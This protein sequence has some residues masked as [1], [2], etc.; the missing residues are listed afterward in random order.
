MGTLINALAKAIVDQAQNDQLRCITVERTDGQ[1]VKMYHLAEVVHRF[2]KKQFHDIMMRSYSAFKERNHAFVELTNL[3]DKDIDRIYNDLIDREDGDTVISM[4]L[5]VRWNCKKD[6]YEF[7]GSVEF[8]MGFA[9]GA[10]VPRIQFDL[11]NPLTNEYQQFRQFYELNDRMK[12]ICEKMNSFKSWMDLHK[13]EEE[14]E[15]KHHYGLT[16]VRK[17]P[18]PAPAPVDDFDKEF[19]KTP[20]EDVED[21][22][23]QVWN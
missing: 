21:I 3:E 12:E 11:R 4:D 19:P 6:G 10:M 17:A 20:D 14:E 15:V 16:P 2:S 13:V 9:N 23:N 18:A 5:P 22:F 8:Y 7:G 1:K